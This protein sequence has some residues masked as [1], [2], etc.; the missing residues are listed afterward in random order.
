MSLSPMLCAS[1]REGCAVV[2]GA[3]TFNLGASRISSTFRLL[4]R[5]LGALPS[6]T[7]TTCL[8][9]TIRGYDLFIR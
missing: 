6:H 3:S 5:T 9:V 2:Y 4:R 1:L 8:L 7:P